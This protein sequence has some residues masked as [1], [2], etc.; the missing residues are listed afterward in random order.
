M[1]FSKTPEL[2]GIVVTVAAVFSTFSVGAISATAAQVTRFKQT[3]RHGQQEGRLGA[4]L[5]G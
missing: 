4:L 3:L 5:R 2:L 1:T